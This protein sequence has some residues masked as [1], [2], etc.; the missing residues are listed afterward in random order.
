MQKNIEKDLG[1]VIRRYNFR[2]TSLIATLYTYRFGKIKGI[3]KGF[4][5]QKREFSSPLEVFS[6]NEFVFYPKKSEIWL[7]SHADLVCDY[8]FAKKDINKARVAAT[9]FKLVDSSMQLW[10]KNHYIFNLTQSCLALLEEENELKILYIFLIKFLTFSGFKPEFNHCINCECL[11]DE[12]VFFSASRGGLT[13]KSCHGKMKD[14]R[15]ITRETSRSL[16]YIQNTD[17]P[18]VCRL[19]LS[20]KCEEEI[21]YI[22]SEFLAYHFDFLMRLIPRGDVV[23]L[24]P[25]GIEI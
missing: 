20:P 6:L 8:D 21:L 9:I 10:D 22:L 12:E 19:N 16:L 11:L 1:F 13:C 23:E 25:K 2:E 5:T 18:N 7:I 15:S 3:F 24:S 14:I 4:Y 17:F